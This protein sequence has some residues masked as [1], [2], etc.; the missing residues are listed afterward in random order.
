MQVTI[1]KYE[2]VEIDEAT[3][4][5]ITIEV[6][7]KKFG[8]DGDFHIDEKGFLIEDEE[9]RGHYYSNTIRK[10]TGKDI[11]FFKVMKILRAGT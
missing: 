11:L 5:E 7:K 1:K 6:L 8:L 3:Q 9:Q 2:T 4:L 10:A